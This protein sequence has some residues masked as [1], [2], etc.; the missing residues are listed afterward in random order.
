[1]IVVEEP[2][3][4]VRLLELKSFVDDRGEFVKTFHGRMLAELGL[5]FQL[6]EEF[7]SVSGKNVVRGMHFQVPPAAHQKMVYCLAGSVLDVLVDLRSGLPTYGKSWSITLTGRRR[8]ALY[9][10]AG[11][12]HGFLSMSENSCMVYKTDH[13]HSPENDMGIRWDSFGF[14]WPCA[15]AGI[16]LSPRDH[17]HPPL[18][19]FVSPF[20]Y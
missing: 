9:I 1:M 14:Q 11:V 15:A 12:A 3:P 17:Q 7:F 8:Q 16:Q 19:D 10:P 20:T 18:V 4:G 2:L 5:S 13:E 6:R